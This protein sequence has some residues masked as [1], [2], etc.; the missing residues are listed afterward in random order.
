MNKKTER[1]SSPGPEHTSLQQ[2]HLQQTDLQPT[3]L[4]WQGDQS[5]G[6]SLHPGRVEQVALELEPD[7]SIHQGQ[8]HL[9]PFGGISGTLRA[10]RGDVLVVMCVRLQGTGNPMSLNLD[11]GP[12]HLGH[13]CHAHE[14]DYDEYGSRKVSD[15][16]G[17]LGQLVV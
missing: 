11:Q 1:C 6:Y 14:Q 12:T 10:I 16:G 17:H 7:R 9:G 3:H 4:D 2:T 5:E 8:G 15:L 13:P